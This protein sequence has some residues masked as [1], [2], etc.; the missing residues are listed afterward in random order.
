[1]TGIDLRATCLFMVADPRWKKKIFVGGLVLMLPVVGWPM[2]LGYRKQAIVNVLSGLDPLLPE[3]RGNYARC[4]GDGLKAMGVIFVYVLP[5][6][7]LIWA[8][9]SERGLPQD[10]SWIGVTLFLL[11]FPIFLPLA[12]P[13]LVLYLALGPERFFQPIEAV[14]L[15]SAY[16][17][18]VFL[19]PL[20]FLQVSRTGRFLSAF[21]LVAAV[22]L[23]ISNPKAYCVA[24]IYSGVISLLGHLCIPLSAW[25]VVW[26]YL[27]IVYC[28]NEILFLGGKDRQLL[29]KSQFPF[30]RDGLWS[31]YTVERRGPIRTFV[32]RPEARPG[33]SSFRTIKIGPVY[34]P[35]G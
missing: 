20:G 8:T 34:A 4:L 16:A 24:W 29:E 18:L 22:R 5:V 28:F 32:A 23:F 19:I 10:V 7:L 31:N 15:A 14:L 17:A 25:G 12:G 21:N 1:M 26:A 6:T 9:F 35:I 30:L 3:W 27:G 13:T 33:L 11:A 2:I